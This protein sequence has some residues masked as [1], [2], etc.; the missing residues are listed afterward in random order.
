MGTAAINDGN[1]QWR[2]VPWLNRVFHA[3][4]KRMIDKGS[5]RMNTFHRIMICVTR[6]RTCERLIQKGRELIFESGGELY[7]VHAIR[8]G[9]NYLGNPNEA[10]ALEYLFRVSKEAGAEM[11]VLRTKNVLKTL[12]DFAKSQKITT[13]ILG[14][15]PEGDSNI[16]MR[17]LQQQ[18]PN[19]QFVVA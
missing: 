8:T 18:L 1:D 10:E 13:L 5:F 3:T 7:V 4:V 6:Q 15:A 12:V 9:E 19:V 2:F 16:L 11:N 14:S 17:E